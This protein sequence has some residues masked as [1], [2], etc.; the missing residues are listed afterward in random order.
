WASASA[1]S[2]SNCCWRGVKTLCNGSRK[3]M[4]P[5]GNSRA[6]LKFRGAQFIRATEV[7]FSTPSNISAMKLCV[8]YFE[9]FNVLTDII[10]TSAV[11]LGMA[12]R[13]RIR[14]RVNL[15]VQHIEHKSSAR[16]ICVHNI[17][18]RH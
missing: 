6:G 12:Y 2:G 1:R 10:I 5:L 14:L 7:I 3:S 13:N 8:R 11:R 9:Q 16:R 18:R 4:K 17:E 15:G